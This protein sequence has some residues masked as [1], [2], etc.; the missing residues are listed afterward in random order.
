MSGMVLTILY[1]PSIQSVDEASKLPSYVEI[2][3]SLN[4]IPLLIFFLLA[5]AIAFGITK[6]F[7][8]RAV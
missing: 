5:L 3:S 8:K 7:T 2:G 6:L 4:V 1:K